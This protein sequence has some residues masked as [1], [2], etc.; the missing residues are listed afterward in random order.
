VDAEIVGGVG[1]ELVGREVTLDGVRIRIV[2]Y[3][4]A[5][6]QYSYEVV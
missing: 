2:R 4:W 1:E 6:H 3:Y 5:R